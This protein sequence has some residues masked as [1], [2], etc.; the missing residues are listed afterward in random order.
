MQQTYGQNC[1]MTITQDH[2]VLRWWFLGTY[3]VCRYV[4]YVIVVGVMLF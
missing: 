3:I 2:D 1:V 4:Q